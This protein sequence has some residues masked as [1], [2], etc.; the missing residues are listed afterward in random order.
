MT[1]ICHYH[2][3]LCIIYNDKSLS[4]YIINTHLLPWSGR[5]LMSCV[6]NDYLDYVLKNLI[7]LE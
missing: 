3:V 1:F 4:I 5:D 6:L 2:H 7:I